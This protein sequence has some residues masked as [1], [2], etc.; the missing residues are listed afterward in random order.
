MKIR[1][2]F[3]SNSSSSSFVVLIPTNFELN[4]S[5]IDKFIQNAE[6]LAIDDEESVFEFKTK[7][8]SSIEDLNLGC[9]IYQ[10][11][12]DSDIFNNLYEYFKENDMIITSVES[13]PDEDKII[14]V[15]EF[16]IKNILSKLKK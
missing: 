14:S 4:D 13:G 10:Q 8:F 1:Q 6:D 5:D 3:V 16:K 7:V 9:T 2:G 12:I 15:T 11:D